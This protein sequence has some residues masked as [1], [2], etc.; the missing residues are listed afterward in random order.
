MGRDAQGFVDHGF[1]GDAGQDRELEDLEEF[2][3]VHYLEILL[4]CF[5][6]SEAGVDDNIINS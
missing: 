2:E 6:E 1:S 5:C 3:L 4:G